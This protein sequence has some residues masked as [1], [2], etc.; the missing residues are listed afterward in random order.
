MAIFADGEAISLEDYKSLSILGGEDKAWR[1]TTGRPAR[2][3]E[4]FSG[5]YCD[6]PWPMPLDEQIQAT[7]ISFEVQRQITA[8]L[9]E[10]AE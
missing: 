3:I 2:R 5:R 9:L 6:Q 8:A 7:R 4:S 1:S 10:R